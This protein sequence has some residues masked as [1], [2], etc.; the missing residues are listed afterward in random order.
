MIGA[1]TSGLQGGLAGKGNSSLAFNLS[2][3]AGYFVMDNLAVGLRL[4]LGYYGTKNTNTGFYRGSS[5]AGGVFGR[6]YVPL[7]KRLKLPIDLELGSSYS[8]NNANGTKSSNNSYFGH[9]YTGISYF[10]APNASVDLLLG[11][12]FS[13]L[14]TPDGFSHK[15][16][17]G[18]QLG[19]SIYLD[20]KKKK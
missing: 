15:G 14:A 10:L 4:G 12:Q 11:Y 7:T 5:I 19:F 1:S 3:N 18:G 2:P 20:G 8:I 17:L 6:Y 9:A 16:S 13:E